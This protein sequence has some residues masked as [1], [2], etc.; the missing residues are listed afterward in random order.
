MR[1]W[2]GSKGGAIRSILFEVEL[3][4]GRWLYGCMSCGPAATD[5][6]L[7]VQKHEKRNARPT[8]FREQEKD[9][10]SFETI[11]S[12]H[13]GIVPSMYVNLGSCSTIAT[14]LAGPE[15]SQFTR[16]PQNCSMSQKTWRQLQSQISEFSNATL[17]MQHFIMENNRSP[18]TREKRTPTVRCSCPRKIS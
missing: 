8:S 2:P 3:M 1:I 5:D 10:T 6:V 17:T 11:V 14:I 9:Q 16:V 15:P 4:N 7:N 12:R 18:R 13:D